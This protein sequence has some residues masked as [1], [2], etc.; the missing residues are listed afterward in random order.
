MGEV[1]RLRPENFGNGAREV[2]QKYFDT[3]A[4]VVMAKANE[5]APL[6]RADC[7]LGWLWFEGFLVVRLDPGEVLD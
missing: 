7:L 5:A 4:E 3:S 6:S 2:V 1:V